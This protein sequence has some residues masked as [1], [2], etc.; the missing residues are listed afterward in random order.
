M[1][2][3]APSGP[4]MSCI[5]IILCWSS[6]LFCF[7]GALFYLITSLQT[8]IKYPSRTAY[9]EHFPKSFENINLPNQQ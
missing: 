8:F 4:I 6:F 1:E 2:V 5:T 3:Q 9:L 7:V